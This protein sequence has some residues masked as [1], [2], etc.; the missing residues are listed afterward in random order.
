VDAIYAWD[1]GA[2]TGTGIRVADLENG[3]RLDHD[4]LITANIRQLSVFGSSGVD[5]GTAVAGIVVGADNGVGTIGIVPNVELGLLTPDR[6]PGRVTNTAGAIDVAA[7][8]LGSG[9]VLLLEVARPFF[10]SNNPDILI[11]F[12]P[13]V[14]G[15][16]RRAHAGSR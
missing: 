11:E 12:D 7:A 15:A 5:H 8:N 3:W 10:P 2:G 4:E 13:A 16:I 14:Q 1:V 9:D 6:G